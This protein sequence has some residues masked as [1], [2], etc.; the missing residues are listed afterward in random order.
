MTGFGCAN[1][2]LRM[3]A[4]IYRSQSELKSEGSSKFETRMAICRVRLHSE[5]PDDG[6]DCVQNSAFGLPSEFEFRVSSF[7]NGS[8]S[9]VRICLQPFTESG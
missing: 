4:A 7:R 1:E 3:S 5:S 9:F 2:L 6:G 8:D